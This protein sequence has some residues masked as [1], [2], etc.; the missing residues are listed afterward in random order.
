MKVDKRTQNLKSYK[1]G[2]SGNSAR[3]FPKG[4]SGNP[5]GVPKRRLEFEQAFNAALLNE[6]TPEEAARILWEEARARQPWAVT[7]LLG[8][9]APLPKADG[10]QPTGP[11]T[12]TV[13][14]VTRQA[15]VV[16]TPLASL[17]L[18]LMEK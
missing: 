3:Q 2:Q 13:Q 15:V 9:I 1:P 7:L 4:V 14:Y 8:R 11:L 12:I 16:A 17:P 5:A 18:A 6:G 10:E